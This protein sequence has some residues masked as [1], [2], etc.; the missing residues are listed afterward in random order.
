M[1]PEYKKLTSSLGSEIKILTKIDIAE[2]AKQ[3]DQI[4]QL[5]LFDP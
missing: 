2:P 1:I 5:G 4:P 3:E